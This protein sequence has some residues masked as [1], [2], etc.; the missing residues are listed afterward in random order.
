ML[1]SKGGPLGRWARNMAGSGLLRGCLP[2]PCPWALC[3]Q[4]GIPEPTGER[5]QCH[6]PGLEGLEERRVWVSV[7]RPL[8]VERPQE[9]PPP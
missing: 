1:F 9:T 3:I 5:P 7:Q 6:S 8:T 4:R 2:L